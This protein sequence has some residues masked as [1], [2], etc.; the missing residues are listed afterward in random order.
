MRIGRRTKV[1][2]SSLPAVRIW[3]V[4]ALLPLRARVRGRMRM[5]YGECEC[6][7]GCAAT[8]G[9]DSMLTRE[10]KLDNNDELDS[11]WVQVFQL[12]SVLDLLIKNKTL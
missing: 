3:R 1:Y 6:D 12:K 9:G 10:E 7:L 2:K 11:C 5:R 8:Y 4:S